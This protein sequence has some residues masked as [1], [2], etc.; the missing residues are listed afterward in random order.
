MI[1]TSLYERVVRPMLFRLEPET[2]HR[3]GQAVLRHDFPWRALSCA[4][5]D[6]RLRTRV[7]DLDL[8]SPIGLAAGFDKNGDSVRGLQHLGFGY[9]TIGSILPQANA[10]NPRPRLIRYPETESLG[11]CYGLPS[12]GLDSCAA[13]FR[14][15]AARGLKTK[16]IANI[17]AD[18][19]ADYLRCIAALAP[20]A[21][22]VELALRCPNRSD[23]QSLY[24]LVDLEELLTPIRQ[25]WPGKA[26]FVKLPPYA[27]DV[28]RQ[29]RMELVE[30]SIRLGLAGLVIPG[31][32]SIPE[33]RLSR[34]LGSLSGRVTFSRNLATVRDVAAVARGRI[35]IKSSG[36]VSSGEEALQ[37]LSAGATMIDILTAFVY[38]GWATAAAINAE[39]AALLDQRRLDS[40]Q[41]LQ[42]AWA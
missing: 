30:L 27:N 7:G 25:R 41:A 12:D 24:P 19:V 34:G 35:A 32:W 6:P 39:L 38:R 15:M 13:K 40:L 31:N 3:L 21:D 22:G 37:I 9:L 10:G 14:S 11:N 23:H 42:P 33:P 8:A 4:A 29:N 28:E 20:Y 18:T 16:L 5:S 26:V 1:G 17:N 36:G 2:A